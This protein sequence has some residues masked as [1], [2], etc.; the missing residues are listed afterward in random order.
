MTKKLVCDT[1]FFIALL[2]QEDTN[3]TRAMDIIDIYSDHLFA[4]SYLTKYELM[5][6]L[7]RKLPQNLAIAALELFENTFEDRFDFDTALEQKV[8]DYYKKS[9]NKNISFFDITCLIQA[10]NWNCKIASFDKFYPTSVLIS[11]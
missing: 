11:I 5:N 4:F 7:S 6:V 3:H 8:I 9:S 2:I 10:Q 1:D